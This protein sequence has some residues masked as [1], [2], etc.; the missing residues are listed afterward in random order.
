MGHLGVPEGW[1]AVFD[2]DL[3]GDWDAKLS[4]ADIDRGGKRIH[5]FRC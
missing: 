5:L 2:P 1:F 3:K 4:H